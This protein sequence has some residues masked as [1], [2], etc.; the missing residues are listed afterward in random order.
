MDDARVEIRRSARRKRTA[1]A[2]REGDRIVVLLPQ[3][4]PAAEAERMTRELVTKVLRREERNR[5]APSDLM[6]RATRLTD[7][8]LTPRL[9][10]TRL[11]TSIDWV[12]NQNQRWGSCTMPDRTIRLSDRLVG[13]PAW[14]IDYVIV[15]ELAHLSYADHSPAFWALVGSFPQAERARGY[16]E[17]YQAGSAVRGHVDEVD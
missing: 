7:R 4:L 1:S 17:G 3:R 15:H 14:V 6:R 9:G 2:Y 11:P 13:M 8:Y 5:S 12:S 10:E 16:L